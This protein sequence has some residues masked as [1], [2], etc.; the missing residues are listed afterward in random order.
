MV[1]CVLALGAAACS[2]KDAKAEA[3]V[4]ASASASAAIAR[5]EKGIADANA[6]ATASREAALSPELRAKRDA[7]LAEPAPEKP[8]Q[9]NDQTRE[10]AAM[11]AWYFLELYRYAYMTGNTTELAAMSDD[12]CQFC[13]S[14]IDRATKLHQNGGW[15]DKWDQ[16]ITNYTYYEK[17]EGYDYNEL[18][19]TI[20]HD[21]MIS[22]PGGDKSPV[23]SDRKDNE[24]LDFA[25]R[26]NGTR[27]MIGE[28]EVINS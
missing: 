15:A 20:N 25:I 5:A 16:E 17:I 9:M 2:V 26:H 23:T 27:W 10:G 4:S 8:E 18:D 6:S 28:V 14:V 7:A 19:V 24:V 12:R 3:S 1:V 21:K 13:K 11:T 22:H